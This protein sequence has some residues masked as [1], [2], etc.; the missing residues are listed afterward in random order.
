MRPVLTTSLSALALRPQRFFQ[1][2]KRRQQLVVNHERSA[3][4]DG[5][6]D[7]VVTAL[8]HI[9]VVVGVHRAT[10]NFAG[11][12][13]D[14]LVGIHVAAGARSGLEDV[15]REMVV[16]VAVGNLLRG[17]DDGGSNVVVQQAEPRVGL[18]CGGLDQAQ[19]ADEGARQAQAADGKII[20]GPLGLGAPQCVGGNPQLAH[21]VVFNTKLLG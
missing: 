19:R 10:Q 14:H 9:D 11:Q 21:A 6:R 20:H 12:M 4:M 13:G 3:D 18:R 8:A 15:D 1:M 5:S 2:I 17:L 7:H 16:V